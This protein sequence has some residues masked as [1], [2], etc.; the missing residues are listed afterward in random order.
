[1]D[2]IEGLIESSSATLGIEHNLELANSLDLA[3]NFYD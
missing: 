3:P 1:M 2:K